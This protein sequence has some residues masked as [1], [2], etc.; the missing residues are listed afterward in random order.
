MKE[1]H[2]I[3]T[4]I[5][6]LRSCGQIKS[7]CLTCGQAT[8]NAMPHSQFSP[9]FIKSLPDFDTELRDSW[10]TGQRQE[11]VEKMEFAKAEAESRLTERRDFYQKY[12]LSSE[13]QSKRRQVIA[14]DGGLCQGCRN[15]QIQEVHHLSYDHLG[16]ELLFELIGLCSKCHRKT[17]HL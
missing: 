14:R 11:I 13:W 5:T 2:H 4:R 1:C 3:E 10:W 6:I 17:H 8:S 12:L 16:D 7:Q 9:E 15:A